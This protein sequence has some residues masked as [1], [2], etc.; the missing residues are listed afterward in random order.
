MASSETGDTREQLRNF[1]NKQCMW[2]RNT[3]STRYVK[4]FHATT[5]C[6][7]KFADINPQNSAYNVSL[8][9]VR[10]K[11]GNKSIV[12]YVNNKL[13]DKCTPEVISIKQVPV[14]VGLFLIYFGQFADVEC[15]F[16]TPEEPLPPDVESVPLITPSILWSTSTVISQD[17]I[18]QE[19][20]NTKFRHLGRAVWFDGQTF[21]LFL[22]S[23]KYFACCPEMGKVPYLG[24]F[25]N[26]L[27]KCSDPIC[28]PCNMENMH[29]NVAEG[30]TDQSSNWQCITCPCL[31]SCNILQNDTAPITGNREYLS[32]LF[33]PKNC[34]K[35]ASLRMIPRKKPA[36][37]S[38][39]IHGI[40]Y[41]GEVV[42]PIAGNF[43][44]IKLSTFYA[45]CLM[46]QCVFLKRHTLQ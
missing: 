12:V 31:L 3:N 35:I 39:V 6:A 26:N 41:D 7:S 29:A 33:G 21:F 13:V 8:I 19:V 11:H 2:I 1:L 28:L 22:V 38:R 43:D 27:T 37:L 42:K 17:E 5:S 32:I 9:I 34:T 10:P 23:Q 14:S 36:K 24:A 16:S 25:V 15:S 4:I 45:R 30:H 20:A 46:Y 40:T 44:L 18:K